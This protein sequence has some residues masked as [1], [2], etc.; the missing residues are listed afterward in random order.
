MAAT[1]PDKETLI[2]PL[3]YNACR[4]FCSTVL[5]GV[6]LPILRKVEEEEIK[7]RSNSLEIHGTGPIETKPPTPTNRQISSFNAWYYGI[8]CGLTGF[9][10]SSLQQIGLI[11]TSVA[12]TAF[13]TSLYVIFVPVVESFLPGGHMSHST[14]TAAAMSI[15]G[16]YFVSGLADTNQETI[17]ETE[18][19]S[20]LIIFIS[21]LFWTVS[22]MASDRGCKICDCIELTAVEFLCTTFF[23]LLSSF[24]YEPEEWV[25][26]FTHIRS[27]GF[28]IVCVGVTEALAFT[29]CSL[30][31]MTVSSSRTAL[32]LSFESL[33]GAL[34]GY[35]FLNE[36]LTWLEILGCALMSISFLISV[37]EWNW[38]DVYHNLWVYMGWLER[39][40]SMIH[41]H[42]EVIDTIPDIPGTN[43]MGDILTDME[44]KPHH[45]IKK[46]PS[47][48]KD[49]ASSLDGTACA[50]VYNGHMIPFLGHKT[51]VSTSSNLVGYQS[52]EISV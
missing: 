33:S 21:M 17:S 31:Q 48:H 39:R 26:P 45:S 40:D 51:N 50:V 27:N 25:Y 32:L 10:G 29:F 47:Q 35:L 3:T 13:I 44:M 12:K 43:E 22:I 52:G 4:Y 5:M 16:T 19:F 34:C 14:W 6:I 30:G 36:T 23:A 46:S 2:G 49:L 9:F 41:F 24:L 20:E 7:S 1:N 42:Y 8:V 15:L 18:G 11:H 37:E 28:Y 38:S